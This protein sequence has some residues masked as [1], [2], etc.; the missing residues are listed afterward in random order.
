[1]PGMDGWEATQILKNDA[2]TKDVLIVAVTARAMGAEEARTRA[3]GA[4]GFVV[5][6]FD[7][8]SLGD[9]IADILTQGRPA[10]EGLQRLNPSASP[11]ESV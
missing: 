1:M 10:L 9:V 11:A 3:V 5:K 8:V 2:R 6:P 7:L 4:D